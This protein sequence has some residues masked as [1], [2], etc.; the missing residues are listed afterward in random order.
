MNREV[1]EAIK[2]VKH[3]IKIQIS[4]FIIIK[5][6]GGLFILLE[7]TFSEFNKSDFLLN[8]VEL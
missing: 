3:S 7:I 5:I 2:C 8:L 4:T 1:S 6:G